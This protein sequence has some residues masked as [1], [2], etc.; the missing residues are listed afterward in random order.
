MSSTFLVRT[1]G[2]LA[3][4]IGYGIGIAQAQQPP[5]E[6]DVL[7]MEVVDD[8]L[9]DQLGTASLEALIEEDMLK[10]GR[11]QDEAYD[12]PLMFGFLHGSAVDDAVR[13]IH[14]MQMTTVTETDAWTSALWSGLF[15]DAGDEFIEQEPVHYFG[16]DHVEPASGIAVALLDQFLVVG[17]VDG[18]NNEERL[19]EA[20]EAFD[21]SPLLGWM[22]QGAFTMH[23]VHYTT[24]LSIACFMD[25]LAHGHEA[26]FRG[27]T[28]DTPSGSF[29][30]GE[31]NEDGRTQVTLS[32]SG[33]SAPN[34]DL[35]GT[36]LTFDVSPDDSE[37][38][39]VEAILAPAAACVDGTADEIHNCD[40]P[41]MDALS[42]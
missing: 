38:G 6:V 1:V 22:P 24:C 30:L 8:F 13:R 27:S 28:V 12:A 5:S 25:R 3:L 14:N 20:F 7:T 2:C 39:F 34:P 17:L 32:I 35:A 40:G 36:T 37:A 4:M 31:A 15:A 10:G 41:L 23:S 21:V 33:E 16:T 11:Y 42:H 29:F 9:P 19:R 26:I 18:P